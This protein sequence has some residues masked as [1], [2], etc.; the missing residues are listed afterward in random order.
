MF[1]PAN[2]CAINIIS[3]LKFIYAFEGSVAYMDVLPC[4]THGGSSLLDRTSSS[5]SI[6]LKSVWNSSKSRLRAVDIL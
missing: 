6:K 1:S 5:S 3:S 4:A 2:C